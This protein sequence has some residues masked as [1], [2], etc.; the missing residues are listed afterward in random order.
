MR[1]ARFMLVELRIDGPVRPTTGAMLVV[2][3]D[4]L[5]PGVLGP[6]GWDVSAQLESHLPES[7][8]CFIEGRTADGRVFSGQANVTNETMSS[9]HRGTTW[10][11]ELQGSGPLEGL[12]PDVDLH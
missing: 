9:S 6:V 1:F 5:R 7:P 2:T 4:E 3:Q 11:I 10:R 8:E 12:D